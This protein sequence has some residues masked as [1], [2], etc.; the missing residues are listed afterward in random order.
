MV[1]ARISDRGVMR[2]SCKLLVAMLFILP[3]RGQAEAIVLGEDAPY[4]G[5]QFMVIE[6]AFEASYKNDFTSIRT[7]GG[8]FVY[9]NSLTNGSSKSSKAIEGFRY[10]GAISEYSFGSNS[11]GASSSYRYSSSNLYP[12]YFS[13]CRDSD[14]WEPRVV[15]EETNF[16]SRLRARHR[17]DS[18]C[19]SSVSPTPVVSQGSVMVDPA[20]AGFEASTMRAV[21]C[22]Q[23]RSWVN[24]YSEDSYFAISSGTSDYEETSSAMIRLNGD[25]MITYYISYDIVISNFE[26]PTQ[27]VPNGTIK[28][29]GVETGGNL[30]VEGWVSG[31]EEA[32][33]LTVSIEGA[34]IQYGIANLTVA[35][36]A[37]RR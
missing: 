1:N 10:D 5:V 32:I 31:A 24:P 28:I 23:H 33:P 9:E 6:N 8:F 30:H 20:P 14:T 17:W 15:Q 4:P 18:F 7:S 27:P 35:N 12:P 21:N 26:N 11:N 16:V 25:P 34:C 36:L 22:K 2:L 13:T 29:D 3:L 37:N 19:V